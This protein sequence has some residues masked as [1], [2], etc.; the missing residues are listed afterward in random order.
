MTRDE[1]L[2]LLDGI[3]ESI[4]R[5][6]QTS[7]AEMLGLRAWLEEKFKGVAR[8]S[9]DADEKIEKLSKEKA[10]LA[11]RLDTE[12]TDRAA[13]LAEVDKQ[14]KLRDKWVKWA[15]AAGVGITVAA[16]FIL[17]LLGIIHF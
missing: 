15:G 16:G 9:E 13:A 11:A 10:D 7:R 14:N 4:T 12:K 3:N 8:D 17:K 5:V 1:A 6:E 2:A